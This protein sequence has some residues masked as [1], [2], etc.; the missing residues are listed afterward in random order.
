MIFVFPDFS[1]EIFPLT[2]PGLSFTTQI[3]DFFQLSLTIGTLHKLEFSRNFAGLRLK[4]IIVTRTIAEF[5]AI[6]K[7]Y[8]MCKQES[9]ANAITDK[10]ARRESMPK[11][12]PMGRFGYTSIHQVATQLWALP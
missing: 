10:P 12:A 11:I 6:H 5:M 7:F 2:F 3:P 8:G 9:P 4:V 1:K